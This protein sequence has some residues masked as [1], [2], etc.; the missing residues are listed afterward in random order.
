MFGKLSKLFGTKLEKTVLEGEVTLS[1]KGVFVA[2]DSSPFKI[3]IGGKGLLLYPEPLLTSGNPDAVD[4]L[5]VDPEKIFSEISGFKRIKLEE[6]LIL[7]GEDPEQVLF[8]GYSN[9]VAMRHLSIE[10]KKDGIL[11]KDLATDTGSNIASMADAASKNKWVENRQ[12][13]MQKIRN[14]YGGPLEILDPE[15]ALNELNTVNV[16]LSTEVY[17]QANDDGEP[18]AL[19]QLPD[20]KAPIILGDIHTNID[21]LIKILSENHF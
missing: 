1:G 2:F 5:L 7:G 3:T 11:F 6:K 15:Q 20:N 17:R 18:G 16:I 9:K 21:N 12:T 8:F 10:Y 13:A 19:I 4:L 14:M